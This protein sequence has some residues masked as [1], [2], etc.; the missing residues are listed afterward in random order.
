MCIYRQ[1]LAICKVTGSIHSSGLKRAKGETKMHLKAVF[2]FSSLLISI[3]F[4]T[5]SAARTT[6]TIENDRRSV[7][8]NGLGRTPQ[9]G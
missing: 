8:E 6:F 7:L 3:G 1:T 2:C 5:T 9:M 4:T